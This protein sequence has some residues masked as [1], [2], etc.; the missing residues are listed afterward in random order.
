[1][2]TAVK[3]ALAKIDATRAAVRDATNPD[4]QRRWRYRDRHGLRVVSLEIHEHL[5][6]AW[7]VDTGR[8]T[9]AQALEQAHVR[10][11][12]ERYLSETSTADRNA[13]LPPATRGS[14]CQPDER[15]NF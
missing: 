7:L 2:A 9:D 3:Q 10:R 15:T 4:R 6:A 11:A 12:L 8:L 1:M 14:L 5:I 13:L